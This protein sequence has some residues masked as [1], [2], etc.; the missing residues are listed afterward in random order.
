MGLKDYMWYKNNEYNITFRVILYVYGFIKNF[1]IKL[2]T[3][4]Y[5][6]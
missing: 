4:S 3:L 1:N 5:W 6:V 2:I